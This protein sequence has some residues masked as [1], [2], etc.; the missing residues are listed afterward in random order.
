MKYR[1][2]FLFSILA[3]LLSFILLES[4][5]RDGGP[6][7]T[8]EQKKFL[9][10][11]KSPP[12]S[13]IKNGTYNLG[14]HDGPIKNLKGLELNLPKF[15]DFD[16]I[17]NC[18]LKRWEYHSIIT[19]DTIITFFIFNTGYA[20]QIT[21]YIYNTT[22]NKKYDFSKEDILGLKTKLINDENGD[23]EIIYKDGEELLSMK[24][25]FQKNFYQIEINLPLTSNDKSTKVIKGSFELKKFYEYSKEFSL[26]FPLDETH[27]AYTHKAPPLYV[28]K[29]N[30]F[31]GKEDI[32]LELK[33]A[34]VT[35]DYTHSNEKRIT[36]WKW[37]NFASILNNKKKI[38]INLTSKERFL[39]R[40]NIAYFDENLVMLG[41]VDFIP[42]SLSNLNWTI[43]NDENNKHI[44][45]LSFKSLESLFVDQNFGLVSSKYAQNIGYFSGK[46]QIEG[47]TI[48]FNDL[49]GVI[50]D[51]YAKW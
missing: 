32:S 19:K 28:S 27:N 12:M 44:I 43:T 51:H 24:F 6:I 4:N 9:S 13:L 31:L 16:Q 42:P 46:I 41:F 45:K 49:L 25:N 18:R 21:S 2:F 40:E 17:K 36:T 34:I 30:L 22:E 10:F 8:N 33:E 15:L 11:I 39:D 1:L 14:L 35:T 48:V 26:F 38:L 5:S 20:S 47:E 23:R 29:A 3:I 37:V 50:E 7:L